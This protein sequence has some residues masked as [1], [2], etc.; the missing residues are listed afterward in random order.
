MLA[1]WYCKSLTSVFIPPSCGQIDHYA[2]DR[3][4]KLIIFHVPQHT[5]LG[6]GVVINT[7]L[8]RRSLF[9]TYEDDGVYDNFNEVNDLIK[10][11][12]GDTDEY[13][14]HRACSSYNP[15]DEVIYSIV[16][17]QGLKAFHKK[18]EIGITPLQY[19]HA[20]PFADISQ[21]AVMKRY[22]LDMMGEVV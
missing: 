11:I 16:T 8:I 5:T 22:V 21:S 6:E 20:N 9:E 13:A 4:S 17:R 10:N 14:L 2:F 12:N 1:F 19:L 18:N 15:L 3:C 7:A